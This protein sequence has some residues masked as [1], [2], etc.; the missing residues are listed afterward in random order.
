[1]VPAL[2]YVWIQ[3]QEDTRCVAQNEVGGE[4]DGED[5]DDLQAE[6][7][8]MDKD[9]GDLTEKERAAATCLGWSN[10][11]AWGSAEGV[12]K[13]WALLTGTE[14]EAASTLGYDEAFWDSELM[15]E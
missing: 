15:E 4:D 10:E 14:T 13:A 11:E 9:W 3:D 2:G 5:Q 7:G 6:A 1:M 12:P 8:S